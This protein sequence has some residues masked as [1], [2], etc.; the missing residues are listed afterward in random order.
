VNT[1]GKKTDPLVSIL[2]CTHN[3]RQYLPEAMRSIFSQTYTNFE[4]ILTRDGGC[5]VNNEVS[6]FAAD[7]RLVFIDRDEN[8]GKAWSLNRA[9][10]RARGKYICYLDDDDAWYPH[11][12]ETLV[13]ALEGQEQFGA[14]YSDLYKAHCRYLSGDRRLVLA[15]NV[16]VSRDFDRLVLLQYNLALHV[17]VMHRRDLL[18]RAGGYNEQLNV[19]ID[20]DLTRRLCFYTD[21][22]HVPVVTGQYYAPVG[23]CARISVRR[24]RNV[25]DYLR[26]LLTIRSTRPPKPWDRIEDMDVFIVA[27]Q[28]G[29]ALNQT[30]GMLWAQ[31]LYPRR[32]FVLLPEAES[33]KFSTGIPDVM[34]VPVPTQESASRVMESILSDSDAAFAAVVPGGIRTE[35]DEVGFLERS[36]NPLL[37]GTES[38]TAYELPEACDGCWGAVMRKADLQ[39]ALRI[40]RGTDLRSAL[41]ASGV[42]LRKP[43]FSQYPFQFDHLLTAAGQIEQNGDWQKAACVYEYIEEN[44][45]NRLWMRTL[46][47]NALYHAG[48]LRQAAETAQALNREFPTVSRLLIEARAFKKMDQFEPA[49]GCYEKAKAILEGRTLK[50]NETGCGPVGEVAGCGCENPLETRQWMH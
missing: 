29:Q 24:R 7:K 47:A 45:G 4:V 34:N 30:L 39:R 3:R 13:S 32:H 11:H 16:E 31:S 6:E 5:A 21:F 25:N 12:V 40:G 8:H 46:K 35:Q 48:R 36:L 18:E 14:A 33:T 28:C 50:E 27:E 2:I 19:L 22:V 23:D 1:G 17:S 44:F 38:G 9:V 42:V 15:K 43:E 10:E 41:V 26:N 37:C 49:I 20:W